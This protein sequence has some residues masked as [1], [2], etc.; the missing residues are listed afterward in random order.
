MVS[1]P[2]GAVPALQPRLDEITQNTRRLVQPER[3]LA[4][5]RLIAELFATGV[6]DAALPLGAQAPAFALPDSTS[7]RPVKVADL[8]A[9]GPLI[10]SF[11]R[12]RWDPYCIT[13]LEA[14]RDLYPEV[15]RRRALLVAISPQTL[16]QAEFAV[17][18]HHL[19]FPLLRDE[20]C[21]VAGAFGIGYAVTPAM[22]RYY[23]S[24]LVSLP[25]L[26]Q[27]RNV[28]EIQA[29]DAGHLPLPGTFL[30]DQS[31]R[32]IFA[33]AH[34]DHRVRPEPRDIMALL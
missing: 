14:W 7:G 24:I 27:G 28:M 29:G 5:E 1:E 8:L 31:G 18:Q 32:V 23:R 19:P 3:L 11:Y 2:A 34:A 12:G 4:S 30:L 25:F 6:E 16:R 20:D 9:L 26:N 13:E 10:V 33:E 22:D 21:K 15:R 17:Q